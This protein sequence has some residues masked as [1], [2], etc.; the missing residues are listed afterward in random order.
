M[1]PDDLDSWIFGEAGN[2][3][4]ELAALVETVRPQFG[5]WFVEGGEAGMDRLHAAAAFMVSNPEIQTQ[6]DAYTFKFAAQV[7]GTFAQDLRDTLKEG[8]DSGESAAQLRKRVIAAGHGTISDY[9]A[10]MIARRESV[11]A[12]EMGAHEAYRQQGVPATVWRAGP[13]ACEFCVALD[14]KVISIDSTFA[15]VGDTVNVDVDGKQR[16]F[17]VGYENVSHPPLHPGCRC[18]HEPVE[19]EDL[20]ELQAAAPAD[21]VTPARATPQPKPEPKPEPKPP[22]IPPAPKPVPVAQGGWRDAKTLKEAE[23][24]WKSQF[25]TSIIYGT[26][27]E[28]GQALSAAARLEHLN[29]I[30]R[31]YSRLRAQYDMLS[32]S[33]ARLHLF[34]CT[35]PLRATGGGNAGVATT[36]FT[37]SA[38]GLACS[39]DTAGLLQ[40]RDAYFKRT[41]F[42]WTVM[43]EAAPVESVFRHELGHVVTNSEY[44]LERWTRE[45]S[46]TMTNDQI[47]KVLSKYATTSPREGVA[48]AFSAITAPD[49]VPGTLPSAM[50]RVIMESLLGM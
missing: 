8:L 35:D 22:V 38:R 28:W 21:P 13:S 24:Q 10:A 6:L 48:E 9:K 26:D 45:V 3:S 4:A 7:G 46:G 32:D 36:G 1:T 30:G 40:G 29:R 11:N 27:Q 34:H 12:M 20:Q 14:G 43:D 25:G 18:D 47:A 50:E 37:T 44:V 42:R 19:L 23:R 41:G 33:G 17:K 5:D 2:W 49:Y 39:P 31:E 16:A 15:N